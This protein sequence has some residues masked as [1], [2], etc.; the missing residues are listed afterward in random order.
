MCLVPTFSQEGGLGGL[1]RGLDN[2]P[3]GRG[4]QLGLLFLFGVSVPVLARKREAINRE[5][6]RMIRS[7]VPN[8]RSRI[9]AITNVSELAIDVAA[10]PPD[11]G[12][13]LV[14]TAWR[15]V[16]QS[17]RNDLR[18]SASSGWTA[19]ASATQWPSCATCWRNTRS[20][21]AKVTNFALSASS[22]TFPVSSRSWILEAVSCA[23]LDRAEHASAAADRE[24]CSMVLR[25]AMS[26]C[27]TTRKKPAKKKKNKC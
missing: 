15:P 16:W 12:S 21:A 3:R 19:E 6:T 7:C 4:C 25:C 20:L 23:V 10:I 11:A 1:V 17:A 2:G 9:D 26:S 22:E 8:V 24:K 18:S 13:S 14:D 5:H 27:Q